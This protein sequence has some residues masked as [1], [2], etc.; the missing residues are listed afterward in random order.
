MGVDG[1]RR[2]EPKAPLSTAE[3]PEFSFDVSYWVFEIK[4]ASLT[5][6][7]RAIASWVPSG[8]QPKENMIICALL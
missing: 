1:R 8:D 2:S 3:G 7:P 4:I 5:E 6:V